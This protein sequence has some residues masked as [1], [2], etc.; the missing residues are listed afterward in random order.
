MRQTTVYRRQPY[1][2]LKKPRI[3]V[4]RDRNGLSQEEREAQHNF[5]FDDY[6]P[7]NLKPQ[8]LAIPL[9]KENP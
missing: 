8:P 3:R 2:H 6:E 7:I 1:S 5:P 4:E 9:K